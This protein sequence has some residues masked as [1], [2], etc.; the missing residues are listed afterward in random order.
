MAQ[1]RMS[2]SPWISRPGLARPADL[3]LTTSSPRENSPYLRDFRPHLRGEPSVGLLTKHRL[4]ALTSQYMDGIY[5][6]VCGRV[7]LALPALN[8]LRVRFMSREVLVEGLANP[9][10][11][12]F[13]LSL[14][15]LF[16]PSIHQS[17][18]NR[19]SNSLL[20][21]IFKLPP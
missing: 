21:I 12:L 14:K 13:P 2:S 15:K 18:H 5:N 7:C 16:I 8:M 10:N 6:D 11:S 19:L 4:M 1:T 20:P 17:H 3:S 9:G